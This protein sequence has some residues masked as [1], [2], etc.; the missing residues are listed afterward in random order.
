MKFNWN[1]TGESIFPQPQIHQVRKCV[2]SG[3]NAASELIIIEVKYEELGASP[4]VWDLSIQEV[5]IKAKSAKFRELAE[6]RGNCPGQLVGTKEH[7]TNSPE[8]SQL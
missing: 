7:V 1:R 6:L 3:S 8:L 4:D 2:D 5:L